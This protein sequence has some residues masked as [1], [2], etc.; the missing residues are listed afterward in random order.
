VRKLEK[1]GFTDVVAV[2]ERIFSIDDLALYPLLPASL[3]ERMR[4]LLPSERQSAVA[5]SLVFTAR[6]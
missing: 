2:D 4:R 1:A 3:I 6:R 5:R